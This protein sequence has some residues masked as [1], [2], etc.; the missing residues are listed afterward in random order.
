MTT[1]WTSSKVMLLRSAC[2]YENVNR[3][4][5]IIYRDESECVSGIDLEVLLGR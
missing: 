2:I 5:K 3:S 4:K 1:I